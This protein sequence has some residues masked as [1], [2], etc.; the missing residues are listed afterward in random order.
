MGDFAVSS[1][2]HARQH[3]RR[4][5]PTGRAR[6]GFGAWRRHRRRPHL[7]G[8]GFRPQRGA[9]LAL[10]CGFDSS[11][12]TAQQGRTRYRMHVTEP[13]ED[14][15][16][17]PERLGPKMVAGLA[18]A[19]AGVA[20]GPGAALA[21]GPLAPLFETLVGRAWEELRHDARERAAQTLSVAAQEAACDEEQFS[22]LIRESEASRLQAG[23]AMD[24][25]QRTVW[26]DK[27]RALGKAL[28]EGLLASDED[29]VDIQLQALDV[30]ADLERLHII[31]LE[32]LVKYEPELG[33]DGFV[34]APH[35]IESYQNRFGGGDRPD[36]PK[37]WSIGRRQWMV[38]QISTVRPQL[39]PILTTLLGTLQRHGLAAEIDSAPAAIKQFSAD[40]AKQVNRHAGQA[41]RAGRAT[42]SRP[43]TIR[44][45]TV[46]AAEPTWAPTEWGEKILGYYRLAGEE[47]KADVPA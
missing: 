20:L 9:L 30:M 36:N 17:E 31:L 18:W 6:R 4:A 24:A 14:D 39:D 37:V 33:H 10:R 25:A 46:P 41:A 21:M 8:L 40:L 32:L 34:A 35:R 19:G 29:Q 47:E 43:L 16:H 28:A 2:V 23:L 11:C 27:V 1:E 26:P 15:D 45:T 13:D 42:S 3:P 12:Q 5:R 7:A 22:E 38:P 44:E